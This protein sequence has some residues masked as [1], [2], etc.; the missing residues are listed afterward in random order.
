MGDFNEFVYCLWIEGIY[1]GLIIKPGVITGN[2]PIEIPGS[3]FF[4]N[5]FIRRKPMIF[6]HITVFQTDCI[7]GKKCPVSATDGFCRGA[8]VFAFYI[9]TKRKL[10]WGKY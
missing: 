8:A 6:G 2:F 10:F 4:R 1:I 3:K 7:S 9:F 5:S